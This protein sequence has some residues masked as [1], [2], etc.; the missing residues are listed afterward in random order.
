MRI[1]IQQLHKKY[2]DKLVLCVP[3]LVIASGELF[4]LVG[5]NGA[6]KTT[7]FRL[8]LDL[9]PPTE[10]KALSGG[11]EVAKDESWK[12]YTGSYLDEGFI[13]DF[14]TPDEF[15]RFVGMTYN[16]SDNEIREALERLRPFFNGEI[17]EQGRKYIRE[18]SKGNIQKIGIAAALL[19]SPQ[20]L[21]L[22]EPFANL[23]P[24]SQISL[25]RMLKALNREK[26]TTIL[27]SSHNLNHVAEICTRIVLLE[28]GKVIRDVR[29]NMQSTQLL[30]EL[31][32]YFTVES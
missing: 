32:A 25:K 9:V 4:G 30:A 21:I 14:L 11:R 20:V 10:G 28:N 16:M 17:L 12:A 15:F 19:S 8:I 2:Q 23:D 26:S 31:E 18:F 13:I 27:I 24:T 7:L 29:N 5:N 22:D 3:E 1:E 6:G